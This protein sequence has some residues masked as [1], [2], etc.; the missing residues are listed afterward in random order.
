MTNNKLKFTL[1]IIATTGVV[2]LSAVANAESAKVSVIDNILNRANLTIA[3]SQ[4]T[5]VPAKPSTG[6]IDPST[7]KIVP[8]VAPSNGKIVP[9]VVPGTGKLTPSL[10]RIPGKVKPGSAEDVNIFCDR[11]CR[12]ASPQQR[13]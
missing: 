9:T 4:S 2:T 11:T 6:Q 5:P 13:K 12:K 10:E 8:T 7:G 3:L 1:G